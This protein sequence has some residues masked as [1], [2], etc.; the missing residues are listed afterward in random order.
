MKN[1]KTILYI[2]GVIL[3]Y[4]YSNYWVGKFIFN[5]QNVRNLL[6]E[7]LKVKPNDL[8]TMIDY[9]MFDHKVTL[10]WLIDTALRYKI[11][12][13]INDTREKY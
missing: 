13:K 3:Y 4:S 10:S 9:I 12:V 5:S 8:L 6:C 7:F 11:E 1:K 2:D